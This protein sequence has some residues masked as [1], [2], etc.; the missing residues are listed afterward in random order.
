MTGQLDA[1]RGQTLQLGVGG[2][3]ALTWASLGV[4]SA[5]SSADR[6]RVGC[7]AA[8]QL[9]D[10]PARLV[11]DDG[12]GRRASS[13]SRSCSRA[14]RVSPRRTGSGTSCR[15]L[16]LADLVE[17]GQRRLRRH[18]APDRLCRPAVLLHPE[19]D[20]EIPARVAGRDR[21]RTAVA[22]AL[23]RRSRGTPAISRAGTPCT[24]RSRPSSIFLFWVYISAVILLYGVEMTAAYARLRTAATASGACR[25][26]DRQSAARCRRRDNRTTPRERAIHGR[27]SA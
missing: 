13:S 3:L 25:Q 21:D 5:V 8:A 27:M 2:L 9:P 18:G 6:S 14:S 1:F 7:R 10:A 12:V 20:D 4:F 16:T 24:D 19:H 17:R 15:A 22:R 23:C 11:P 26:L